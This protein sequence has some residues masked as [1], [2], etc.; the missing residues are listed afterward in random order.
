MA[1]NDDA[2]RQR[3]TS[4]QSVLMIA[5]IVISII[6]AGWILVTVSTASQ[7]PSSDFVTLPNRALSNKG[8]L[9]K[10]VGLTAISQKGVAVGVKGYLRTASGAPV[11]GATIYLTYFLD[12]SYR[13]QVTTTDQN[14]YFQV[15]FPMNWTGWLPLNAT[16]FGDDQHQGQKQDF[17]ISGE[18][19]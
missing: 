18:T 2:E 13:T 8:D 4:Y 5:V 19:Q 12:F 7:V 17:S 14:G 6:G 15:Y 11:A 1:K 16:Y 3:R 9:V 10:F